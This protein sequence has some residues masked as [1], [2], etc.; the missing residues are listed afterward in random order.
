MFVKVLIIFVTFKLFLTL[1]SFAGRQTNRLKYCS[2]SGL[3]SAKKFFLNLVLVQVPKILLLL[4]YFLFRFSKFCFCGFSSD[5]APV[6]VQRKQLRINIS[7]QFGFGSHPNF[8]KY[9]FYP[10]LKSV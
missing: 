6:W 10:F 1:F 2:G 9:F 5:L 3:G 7:F 8:M 4:V